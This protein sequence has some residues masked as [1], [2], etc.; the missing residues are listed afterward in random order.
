MFISISQ[1]DSALAQK[2]NATDLYNKANASDV[3]SKIESD[4]KFATQTALDLKANS[5]DPSFTGTVFRDHQGHGRLGE[6]QQYEAMP[7]KP[8]STQA[9]G[10]GSQG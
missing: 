8:V 1:I 9:N 6:C 2:A 4:S 7:Q 3:Y 5:A 10:T